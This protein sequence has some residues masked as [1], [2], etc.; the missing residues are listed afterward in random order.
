[1]ASYSDNFN[2]ASLGTGY[3]AVN[4]GTW[5]ITSSAY[6]TQAES[7]G[8]YRV[9]RY[10]SA[11]DSNDVDI[12]CNVYVVDS[13]NGAGIIARMPNTGVSETDVDGYGIIFFPGDTFYLLR[14]DSGADN[15]VGYGYSWGSPSTNTYYTLRLTV[16]GSTV[17]GYVD[18]VQ[19]FQFTDATYSGSG[20][21]SFGPVSYGSAVG[22]SRFDNLSAVDI[23]SGQ[24]INLN[25]YTN[26]ST[27]HQ[28]SISTAAGTQTVQ[29]NL[30]T[31]SSTLHQ[32]ALVL[33]QNISPNRIVQG[34]YS[35][36]F[37]GNGADVNRVRIPLEDGVSTQY[38]V[39]VGAGSFTVEAWIKAN[40]SENT[41]TATDED[42]RYSNI[43]YDRDSWGEQRGH[44]I[45]VTRSGSNLV[46]CFGQAGS[47]GSWS[48]IF[49]T[50]NIGDNE[51]H[52]I[53]VTRNISGGA[54]K[55]FVDGV[56]EASGTYD[57]SDW[58]YPPG[59]TVVSGQDN[60]YLVLGCEK[61]DV[62]YFFTGELDEMRI[63]DN[64]RY[65]STFSPLRRLESD[66]NTSAL[67]RFDSGSGTDFIDELG[68]S[69]G[70]LAV[71]GS[72]SGP[73]WTIVDEGSI[74]YAPA[75]TQ[76]LFI[77]ASVLTN[78]SVIQQ[79]SVSPGSVQISA[80]LLSNTSVVYQ[81]SVGTGITIIPE[82]LENSSVIQQPQVTPGS[83]AI[84]ANLLE[85][86]ST[87]E[88][89]A[90]SYEVSANLLENSSTIYQPAIE[91][92]AVTISLNVLE[93]TSEI[94]EVFVGSGVTIQPILISSSNAVEQ[95][96]ITTGA[97]NI[98][99]N[100]IESV[101][102]VYEPSLIQEQFI[103]P[104]VITNSNE[105]YSV[106]VTSGGTLV[107][108]E[109]LSNTNSIYDI[110]V[111]VGAVTIS[112]DSINN[113]NSF[114]DI[115]VTTTSSVVVNSLEN[116]SVVEEPKLVAIVS[117]QL[118]NNT[119]SLPSVL[120]TTGA[121]NI[122]TVSV[123]SSAL[124][125]QPQVFIGDS[126]TIT[127]ILLQNTNEFYGALLNSFYGRINRVLGSSRLSSIYSTIRTDYVP[128]TIR[129]SEDAY[130]GL[131]NVVVGALTN[132]NFIEQPTLTVGG[133]DIVPSVLVNTNN[134]YGSI[135]EAGTVDIQA[136]LLTNNIIVYEP[137]ITGATT[138]GLLTGLVAYW[139]L[140][141]AS[142]NA[143]DKHS[144]GLTLSAFGTPGADT[145]KVYATARTF[146]GVYPWQGFYR[147][148][149]SLLQPGTGSFGFA[150]WVLRSGD[151]SGRGILGKYQGDPTRE[152]AISMA[153]GSNANKPVF[154]TRA[155]DGTVLGAITPD[156][157]TDSAWSLIIAWYDITTGKAY[158]QMN[159]STI[160]E[161]SGTSTS[162]ATNSGGV[163]VV[164][165]YYQSIG[166]ETWSGR[167]G[168][169]AFW[170]NRTLSAA[171]RSA[172]WNGGAGLA[173]S[174]FTE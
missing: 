138:N 65:S 43:I 26:T 164:G 124:V 50:S 163:F 170:K 169:V 12:S 4:G 10:N 133:V 136:N 58:S 147:Y 62:G 144:N 98:S 142:G 111:S 160:S 3:T 99:T 71:G 55:I 171:D 24:A 88:E 146:S 79:P 173:Y 72:P 100:I 47:G 137:T 128:R 20:N 66:G 81:P 11:M 35:L 150:V 5:A 101:G 95:P 125:Y 1:M 113:I 149:E 122:E 46:A 17:T 82:L 109:L 117:T 84:A 172:L 39:N 6:L 14:F 106:S 90:L 145:G 156:A 162:G 105:L 74:V 141:E 16:Q 154:S 56:E 28:P 8:T 48:T 60:E 23:V 41:T 93:N 38:P 78:T 2:R 165:D 153:G 13:A 140:D 91:T 73:V 134:F 89:P 103:S 85:N 119:S 118:I 67:Y 33:E 132:I 19:R 157:L 107:Q 7:G 80:N 70:T 108:P 30:L 161:S 68:T 152:Y 21:R 167:I 45:G 97:V 83:V 22:D 52:H 63:S 49:S 139:G 121:V 168:P 110:I 69:N 143:A 92:Q 114:G 9:L 96:L 27:I 155:S 76:N 112:P 129:A 151:N 127:P 64:V 36:K 15:G 126:I 25:A 32:P 53:A 59:H 159:N 31:N 40:Y 86:S 42:A 123:D 116:N 115:E 77:S 148:S 104:D 102:E 94:F 37:N 166:A 130:A 75:V 18:G 57:T 61:H 174:A 120:V 158:I 54:V 87:I 51:W 44:V 34:T 135:I 131:Q 29:P